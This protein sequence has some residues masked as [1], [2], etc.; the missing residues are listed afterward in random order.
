MLGCSSDEYFPATVAF[1]RYF[2]FALLPVELL[3]LFRDYHNETVLVLFVA[4]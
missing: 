1:D 3:L 2:P 4:S